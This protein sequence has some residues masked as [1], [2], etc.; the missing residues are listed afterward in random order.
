MKVIYVKIQAKAENLE[1]ELATCHFFRSEDCI[2]SEG[3]SGL[4]LI[5]RLTK[6]ML[7]VQ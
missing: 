1:H 3:T 5:C 2:S 4:H 7:E 6:T